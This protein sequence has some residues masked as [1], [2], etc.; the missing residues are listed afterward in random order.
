MNRPASGSAPR[1]KRGILRG[2]GKTIS[3][4]VG[5]AISA[6]CL[7]FLAA[8]VNFDVIRDAVQRADRRYLAVALIAAALS[9]TVRA[10]RIL[11]WTARTGKV[12]FASTSLSNSLGYLALILIPAR[13]GEFVRLEL[14]SQT[15]TMS[16]SE[17]LGFLAI[18][19]VVDTA[20]VAGVTMISM[21]AVTAH[22]SG[23]FTSRQL[24]YLDVG[25]AVAFASAFL[26]LLLLARSPTVAARIARFGPA[27][28]RPWMTAF[29]HGLVRATRSSSLPI[30]ISGLLWLLEFAAIYMV[31]AAFSA[32]IPASR[33]A[34]LLGL[35]ALS[36]VIPAGP[37]GLGVWQWVFVLTLPEVGASEAV[38]ISA[39]AQAV[40]ISAFALAAAA[41]A[42]GRVFERKDGFAF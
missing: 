25:V 32:D 7:Y 19:R 16:R 41:S 38:V 14:L 2:H 35:M 29:A 18:E 33:I 37:A 40:S 3:L 4:V 12:S 28:A 34:L 13:L 30:L 22:T 21:L 5:L 15:L 24:L 20:L 31:V 6:I 26:V 36:F 17:F 27:F 39:C 10:Y 42:A 23:L 11:V 1:V 8:V 9:V